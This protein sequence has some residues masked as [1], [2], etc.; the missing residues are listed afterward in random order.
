MILFLV[1]LLLFPALVCAQVKAFPTAE[2]FGA[3]SVGGRGGVVCPVTDTSDSGS[4]G[5]LRYCL[6][7]N[8]PRTVIFR[9]SGT[10][11]LTDVI[12][13]PSPY[14]TI[15][16][17]TSPGGIQIKGNQSTSPTNWG[18]WFT[19]G[20][21]DIIIRHLRVRTG[22]GNQ[23]DA[24]ANLLFYSTTSPIYNVI[25]DHC[26]FEWGSDS[27]LQFYG[28]DGHDFTSQWN[29]IAEGAQNSANENGKGD[30]IGGFGGFPTRMSVHHNAYVNNY[31]RVPLVQHGSVIDFRNNV[32][33]NWGGNNGAVFGQYGTHHSV[34]ANV[35]NNIWLVGPQSGTPFLALGNGGPVDVAGGSAEAG[36]TKVF[37]SGNWG[38]GCTSGCADQW[39]GLSP[40]TWD[41]FEAFGDGATYP[42]P[43]SQ[44]DAGS[45]YS[46]ASVTTTPTSTLLATVLPVV[47]AT[48]PLRDSASTR[49]LTD[50][51]TGGG[52]VFITSGGPWPTFSNVTPPVDSDGDGIPDAW[53]SSH[54]L[55]PNNASDGAAITASG[56]SNLEL[57]LN[58]LA[59]DSGAAPSVPAPF[60]LRLF[61]R[62]P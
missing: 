41:R 26:D 57:Y 39:A 56:Y 37:L 45:A 32:I 40:N 1:L 10:I 22:G 29:L 27:Q 14:L 6:M 13:S 44:F 46:V 61:G 62:T 51:Q 38:P 15:A 50:A 18:I 28:G 47:G 35:I 33:Y 48:V 34:F 49:I 55:N 20:S 42:A 58:E 25:V 53:E 30:H 19:S 43:Q 16:G 2:G 7:L 31:Q 59:G 54:G 24:G 60:N 4:P 21:H 9:T 17:Q 36:G 8:Q 3:A 23:D 52:T 5:S 12:Q 11:T